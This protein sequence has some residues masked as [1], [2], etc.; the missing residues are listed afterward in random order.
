MG[1]ALLKNVY[2]ICKRHDMKLSDTTSYAERRDMV[3]RNT[4]NGEVF[5]PTIASHDYHHYRMATSSP[6][7][8]QMFRELVK[9]SGE[10]WLRAASPRRVCPAQAASSMRAPSRFG[11]SVAALRNSAVI[12]PLPDCS[13]SSA[14]IA[15]K[16]TGPLLGL[17]GIFS[18]GEYH[19]P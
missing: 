9:T 14:G 16:P 1:D 13:N 17:R 6:A 2:E 19:M 18:P 4:S 15:R 11:G 5:I 7:K 10:A 3:Y 12:A 8:V